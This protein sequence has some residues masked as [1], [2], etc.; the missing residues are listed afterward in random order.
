MRRDHTPQKPWRRQSADGQPDEAARVFR[1]LQRREL[2]TIE[3]CR[4]AWEQE[5]DPLAICE[6]V[7][8]ASLPDWLTS[9]ILVLVTDGEAGY[10]A[11]RKRMWKSRTEAA[12][13]A[14]RAAEIAGVRTHPQLPRTWELSFALGER[15]AR[16]D[17]PDID[18]VGN[19]AAKRSYHRV[20]RELSTHPWRFQ[21]ARPGMQA[22]I[23]DAWGYMLSLMEDSAR[24]KK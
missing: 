9:A 8:Q 4:Q 21:R 19:A 11:L 24:R 6:A 7:R 5:H 3:A 20:R 1:E 12:A 22:R 13:D 2:R 14:T 23:R 18:A 17:Y 16:D 15:F 10:P